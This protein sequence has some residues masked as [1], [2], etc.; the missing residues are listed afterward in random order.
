M[1]A[2]ITGYD[3]GPW[4]FVLKV[5]ATT[6]DGGAMD[7]RRRAPAEGRGTA[8]LEDAPEEAPIARAARMRTLHD[9]VWAGV[10]RPPADLVAGAL[11][12]WARDP[13]PVEAALARRP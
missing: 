2:R 7:Q 9:Q 3:H 4:D 10:Y 5:G 11:L 1:G 13:F 6:D 12:A 8:M